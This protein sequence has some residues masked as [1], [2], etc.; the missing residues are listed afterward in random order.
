[1]KLQN[2]YDTISDPEKRRAYDKKW[3]GI[4]DSIRAKQDSD[5]RQAGTAETEK[6]RITKEATEKQKEDDAHKER[7]RRL[8][9][10]KSR[11]NSDIFEVNRVINKLKADLKRLQDYDNEDLKKQKEQNS[12]WAYLASPIYSKMNETDEQKQARETERL[13]RVASRTIKRSELLEKETKLQRLQDALKNVNNE[14]AGEKKKAEDEARAEA[15]AQARK[16][17][18]R[19]EHEAKKFCCFF[20]P[21][22]ESD[23]V[24]NRPNAP[25]KAE[26]RDRTR[27]QNRQTRLAGIVDDDDKKC[28]V[29][30]YQKDWKN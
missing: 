29:G 5:R 3:T 17:N 7:L 11:Y 27:A 1:M 30:D 13:H 24:E 19:M 14:I 28:G 22:P 20:H 21:A 8:E 12:W 26:S 25:S 18:M 10:F 9:I 23:L 15:Q 16:E 2:A 6:G 4:R